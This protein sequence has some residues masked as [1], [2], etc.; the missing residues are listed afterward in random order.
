MPIYTAKEAHNLTECE[1][2]RGLDDIMENIC[3]MI[4]TAVCDGKFDASISEN[5]L[6]LLIAHRDHTVTISRVVDGLRELGYLVRY[7]QFN[8]EY[9]ISWRNITE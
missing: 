4:Y 8:D 7:N 2:N 9:C 3:S 5:E 6:G 1:L